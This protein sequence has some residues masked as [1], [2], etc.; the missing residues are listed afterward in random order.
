ML[1]EVLAVTVRKLAEPET[2]RVQNEAM[3]E[4]WGSSSLLGAVG[5][6]SQELRAKRSPQ[7][8]NS[9]PHSK[10]DPDYSIWP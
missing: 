4:K 8:K 3:G 7:V 10:P 9:N 1:R 6:E 5:R 2:L